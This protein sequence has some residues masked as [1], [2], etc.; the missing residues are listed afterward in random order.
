MGLEQPLD[1]DQMRTQLSLRCGM[2]IE[3]RA[4]HGLLGAKAYGY[5]AKNRETGQIVVGYEARIGRLHR[6]LVILHEFA[7]IM[8]G[9]PGHA[10]DHSYRADPASEFSEISLSMVNRVLG[11]GSPAKLPAA[12]RARRVRRS[13]YDDPFEWEAETMATIML[14]W[15]SHGIVTDPLRGPFEDALGCT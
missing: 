11:S 12:S 15:T 4:E 8:L 13:L 10:I 14:G 2:A 7:H 6:N 1:L 9:H 5:T 3:L